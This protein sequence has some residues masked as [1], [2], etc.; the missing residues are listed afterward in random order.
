MRSYKMSNGRIM[1]RGRGGRFRH[2][3]LQDIGIPA[4]LVNDRERTCPKCGTIWFPILKTGECPTC[5]VAL[6]L[7]DCD[8][9]K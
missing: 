2:A 3:T 5:H 7:E 1:H 9:L 4:Y 8:A 6:E